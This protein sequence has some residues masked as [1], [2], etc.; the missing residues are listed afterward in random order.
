MSNFKFLGVWLDEKLDNQLHLKAKKA[1]AMA[2]S[3]KLAKHGL[4][5]KEMS[6]DLKAFLIRTFCRSRMTYGLENVFLTKK[7]IGDLKVVEGKIIKRA[8]MLSKFT[9]TSTIQQAL[10]LGETDDLIKLQKLI[11]HQITRK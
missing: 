5:N 4:L 10:K 8:L 1:A 7:D 6:A 9:S 2:A 3:Y 11:F